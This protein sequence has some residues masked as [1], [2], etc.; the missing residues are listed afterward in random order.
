MLS[1]NLCCRTSAVILTMMMTTTT[2]EGWVG[3]GGGG[4]R[5]EVRVSINPTAKKKKTTKWL[6]LQTPWRLKLTHL[7][8][9]M[10]FY[11]LLPWRQSASPPPPFAST[12]PPTSVIL[13]GFS[14][15]SHKREKTSPVQQHAVWLMGNVALNNEAWVHLYHSP[16]N[17]QTNRGR[18]RYIRLFCTQSNY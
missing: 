12:F 14:L 5:V 16:K 4:W 11:W 2:T 7:H 10:S 8:T 15:W 3:G 1:C 13:T 17:K 6:N 18:R 9:L